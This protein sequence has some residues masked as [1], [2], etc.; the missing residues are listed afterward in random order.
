MASDVLLLKIDRPQRQILLEGDADRY[1][2]PA[3]AITICVP[4]MFFHPVDAEQR[5]ELW[6]ARLLVRV[7]QGVRELLVS[8]G[9]T[10]FTPTTNKVRRRRAE[11]A[12][13]RGGRG[14]GS[15]RTRAPE[16][17]VADQVA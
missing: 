2:I 8:P 1:R 14:T 9:T 13:A 7:E 3:A 5:N 11:N 6:M 16:W 12:V 10:R 4:Q 15:R 17:T